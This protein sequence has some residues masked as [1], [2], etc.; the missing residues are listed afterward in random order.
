MIQRVHYKW[1]QTTRSAFGDGNAAKPSLIP[2]LNSFPMAVS[3][4]TDHIEGRLF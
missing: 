4:D 1:G 2:G 3:S